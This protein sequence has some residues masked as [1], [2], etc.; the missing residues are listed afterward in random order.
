MRWNDAMREGFALAA[1]VAHDPTA[2]QVRR[3]LTHEA[4]EPLDDM[5]RDL[6]QMKASDRRARIAAIAARMSPLPP[7]NLRASPRA[8]ALLASTVPRPVGTAWLREGP[9]LRAG[10][11]P[12]VGLIAALRRAASARGKRAPAW[13]A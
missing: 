8:R 12:P 4:R 3:G 5:L 10:Y 6:A 13:H 1:T 11:V 2:S 9:P 7:V